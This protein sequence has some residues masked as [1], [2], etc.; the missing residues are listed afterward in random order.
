MCHEINFHQIN[1]SK[2]VD[3]TCTF[4]RLEIVKNIKNNIY[5]FGVDCWISFKK[6][7]NV[8]NIERFNWRHIVV[9]E[10]LFCSPTWT[11][12]MASLNLTLWGI[13][14]LSPCNPTQHKS[15]F[16]TF[17]HD[18]TNSKPYRNFRNCT[19]D[20]FG[21][22]YQNLTVLPVYTTESRKFQYGFEFYILWLT[23]VF[24]LIETSELSNNLQSLSYI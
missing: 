11:F 10:Q 12:N 1:G 21:E 18:R 3:T 20:E 16:S 7:E 19:E 8:K 5:C 4:Q 9:H 22:S 14:L 6:S 17:T 24:E 15:P 23:C 13:S 2:P